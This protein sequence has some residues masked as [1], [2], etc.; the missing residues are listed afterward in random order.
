MEV[1]LKAYTNLIVVFGL[2]A[3]YV[4]H[5]RMM[6]RAAVRRGEKENGF[7]LKILEG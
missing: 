3:V 5:I 2:M 1:S 7:K 4:K 6:I